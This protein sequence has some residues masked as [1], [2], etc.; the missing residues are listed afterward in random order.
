MRRGAWETQMRLC[1]V[2]SLCCAFLLL[3][4][5]KGKCTAGVPLGIVASVVAVIVLLLPPT[6]LLHLLSPPLP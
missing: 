1:S 2:L 5:L 3:E 6:L 4:P